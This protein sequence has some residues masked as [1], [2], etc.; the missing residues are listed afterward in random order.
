M[1][2]HDEDK[3]LLGLAAIAGG[4]EDGLDR[5][6]CGISTTLADGR[7]GYLE[8]WNPLVSDGDAMRCAWL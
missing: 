5:L 3:E 6:E 4:I 1:K 2:C 8:K 7:S